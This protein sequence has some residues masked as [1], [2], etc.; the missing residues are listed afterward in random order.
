M[1]NVKIS[2]LPAAATLTGA[3]LV[4]VVQS[5]ATDQT[6]TGAIAALATSGLFKQTASGT[7]GNTTVP[8][9]ITSTG[10]GS[11]TLAA[12]LLVAGT[13]IKLWLSGY[14]SAVAN[15]TLQIQVKFGATVVLDTGAVNTANS[16]NAYW[17]L[18]ALVTCRTTGAGGTIQAEGQYTEAEAGANIFG[19][20]NTS[21]V[22]LDTTAS[23]AITVVV[24]WGT[25]AVGN[26][27][28]CTN[29]LLEKVG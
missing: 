11:K 6:T 13:T 18:R 9:D 22:A 17:E 3:E 5:G 1:A 24:T 15:P 12:N 23:Q 26:T 14:H 28:T 29:F 21:T 7:V 10:V 27:I 20:V 19:M 8:T 25:A 4:P 2:A 16:T